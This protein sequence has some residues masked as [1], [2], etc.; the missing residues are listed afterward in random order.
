MNPIPEEI[1]KQ[2]NANLY[3]PRLTGHGMK[4]GNEL[5]KCKPQDWLQDAYEALEVAKALGE[6]VILKL[7]KDNYKKPH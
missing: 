1:A 5:L 6:K 2:M 7:T 3:L 4:D